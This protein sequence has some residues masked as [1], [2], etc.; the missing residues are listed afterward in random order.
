MDSEDEQRRKKQGN[1]IQT[2]GNANTMNINNM[3]Y[4]NILSSPYFKNNL[5]KLKTYH[6]VVD[7]IYYKVEHLE[8]WE[9]GSRKTSGQVGMC[10]G[11]RGVGAGGIVSSCYCLLFKIFTLK[12]TKKQLKGLLDHPDSPYIRGIGFMY[13]RYCMQPKDMWSWIEPYLEDEEEIDVKAGGGCIMTIGQ[14]VRSFI[15]KLEWYGTLFPR[16]PVPV[17]K[18]IRECLTNLNLCD[19]HKRKADE[20]WGEAEKFARNARD[21]SSDRR[22]N[23]DRGFGEAERYSKMRRLTSSRA[24]PSRRSRSRD[25]SRERLRRRSRDRSRESRVR[26][27]RSRDRSRERGERRRSRDRSRERGERRRS[28]DRSRERGDRRRSRDRSRNRAVRR[29]RSRSRD[30]NGRRSRERSRDRERRIHRDRSRER[31][32]RRSRDR[33]RERL[34]KRNSSRDRV[35]DEQPKRDRNSEHG[36]HKDERRSS[37]IDHARSLKRIQ[38]KED[39]GDDL[40][41]DGRYRDETEV[42]NDR[43]RNVQSSFMM[44]REDE[45]VTAVKHSDS[46]DDSEKERKVAKHGKKDKKHKKKKSKKKRSKEKKKKQNSDSD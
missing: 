34:G 38:E 17:E 33:S 43:S 23:E 27:S 10:G 15:L 28:R 16:I 12:L 44:A 4:T 11:V 24:S 26:R 39:V 25:Q 31:V 29:E 19:D 8:P 40:I 45:E 1:V 9:K 2:W 46:S 7:E 36:K 30:K 13:I 20:G 6:E 35:R 37:S 22:S 5:F 32:N 42:A 14:L 3:V 41:G 18:D 21:G